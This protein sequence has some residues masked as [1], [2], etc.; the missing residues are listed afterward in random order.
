M[1]SSTATTHSADEPP[2]APRP[3][4]SMTP[5]G[6]SGQPLLVAGVESLDQAQARQLGE[7]GPDGRGVLVADHDHRRVQVARRP[8]VAGLVADG[9]DVR[10][11]AQHVEAEV[12]GDEDLQCG[13]T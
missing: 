13:V 5:S 4:D 10:R 1:A 12:V 2:C 7:P 11:G 8:R 9:L 3:L 6:R